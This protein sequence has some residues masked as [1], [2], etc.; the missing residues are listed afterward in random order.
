MLSQFKHG[1]V[2][3]DVL[4]TYTLLHLSLEGEGRRQPLC[5]EAVVLNRT[6]VAKEYADFRLFAG[7]DNSK[8]V[9]RIRIRRI[10]IILPDTDPYF[11]TNSDPDLTLDHEKSVKVK[12]KFAK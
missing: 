4:D 3:L 12:N 6:G 5:P 1:L 10:S 8:S 11:F 2:I 9:L 7:F